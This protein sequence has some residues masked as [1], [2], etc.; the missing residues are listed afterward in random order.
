MAKPSTASKWSEYT[1]VSAERVPRM[2]GMSFGEVGSG[3]TEFW[4]GGPGPVLVLS[5]D[6]GLEGVVEKHVQKGKEIY[7]RHYDWNP[8]AE[9]FSQD[10][11]VEIREQ[12][13]ADFRFGLKHA[14][15]ILVDKET[16][17][18]EIYR[19]AEFGGP[20]DAPK[21]YAKLNQR[22]FRLINEAKQSAGVNVGFIQSMKDE[23]G[24]EKVVDRNSGAMKSKPIQTGQRK[25][26][27][28]SRLDELVQVEMRH[29]VNGRDFMI[30]IGKCRLNGAF[31]NTTQPGMTFAEM[32]QL[33]LTTTS[34]EDWQ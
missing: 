21:D 4:L 34:E 25:R 24:T 32:G 19:Y 17:I 18:W 30:D 5:P 1:R 9:G 12:F 29:Y 6:D 20:S 11:A 16:D 31:T 23:W 26:Q 2:I 3:K 7:E 10:Y 27:G 33:L 8:E 13:I 15:T 22:Y 28:F 14:R